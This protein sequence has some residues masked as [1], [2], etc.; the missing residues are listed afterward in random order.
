MKSV[1]INLEQLEKMRDA[2]K[3]PM[4]V[5][6]EAMQKLQQAMQEC[7][8]AADGFRLVSSSAVDLIEE[9]FQ[10]EVE[11]ET[12]DPPAP[13]KVVLFDGW[14]PHIGEDYYAPD[15]IS[16]TGAGTVLSNSNDAYDQRAIS[17]AAV[18]QTGEKAALVADALFVMLEL[19]N[20]EGAGEVGYDCQGYVLQIEPEG[21]IRVDT[22]II[23]TRTMIC[24][25]FPSSGQLNRAVEAVGRD[26][27]ERAL[28]V[29]GMFPVEVERE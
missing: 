28:K 11:T 8:L 23:P 1:T 15:P 18:F 4:D 10:D 19:R 22:W 2:L 20:Q 7:G 12:L 21:D 26:R 27:V 16:P 9:V 29:W 3:Q 24:P 17:R 5:T 13:S 25:C 14:V 6:A